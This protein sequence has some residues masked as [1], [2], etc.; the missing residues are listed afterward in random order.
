[1]THLY[2]ITGYK[3]CMHAIVSQSHINYCCTP[4]SIKRLIIFHIYSVT[5]AACTIHD[6]TI[7]DE[8]TWRLSLPLVVEGEPLLRQ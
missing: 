7:G 3:T 6:T 2:V 8:D 5:R 1:M 4:S